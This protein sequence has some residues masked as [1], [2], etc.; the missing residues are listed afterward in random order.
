MIHFFLSIPYFLYFIYL[1]VFNTQK[2]KNKLKKKMKREP[3]IVFD[4]VCDILTNVL[5]SS[6]LKPGQGSMGMQ[7][8]PFTAFIYCIKWLSSRFRV[9]TSLKAPK[10]LGSHNYLRLEFEFREKNDGVFAIDQFYSNL[11]KKITRICEVTYQI[12][13]ASIGLVRSQSSVALVYTA[14]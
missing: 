14:D 11:K 2:K 3:E 13:V 12:M 5:S 10:F 7:L 4:I 6:T 8:H 9:L 1:D